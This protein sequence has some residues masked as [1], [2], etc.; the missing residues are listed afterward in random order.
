MNKRVSRQVG[1]NLID[2]LLY[3]QVKFYTPDPAQLEEEFTRYLF[4]LQIKLDLKCGRLIVSDN[5]AAL[6]ASYLVQGILFL[7]L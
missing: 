5:T 4:S 2:P 3:F 7:P 6:L 1:L